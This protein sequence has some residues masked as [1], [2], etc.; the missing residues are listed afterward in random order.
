[1]NGL[2]NVT[3]WNTTNSY[4]KND[5]V[6]YNGKLFVS[7]HDGN[8]NNTP[9]YQSL[10]YNDNTFTHWCQEDFFIWTP[11]YNSSIPKSDFSKKIP[12]GDGYAKKINTA[13]NNRF[14]LNLNFNDLD[15]WEAYAISTFLEYRAG[16]PFMFEIPFPYSIYNYFI[17]NQW[18]HTM[19]NG[20][21]NIV[22][23]FEEMLPQNRPSFTLVSKEA[24]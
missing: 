16:T 12:L 18:S 10:N 23:I 22:A 3:S 24:I 9:N 17:T 1:M 2:D 14:I 4:Q 6:F 11:S 8:L 15:H 21:S 20:Y 19:A 5:L 7:L 13:L